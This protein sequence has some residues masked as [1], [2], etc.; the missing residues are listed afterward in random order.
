MREPL[1]LPFLELDA[2]S[3]KLSSLEVD[4]GT[5]H[6]SVFERQKLRVLNEI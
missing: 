3:L 2:A 1:E 5:M 4:K 6:D